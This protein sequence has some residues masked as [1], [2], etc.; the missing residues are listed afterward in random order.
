M[1]YSA[2]LELPLFLFSLWLAFV[3]LCEGGFSKAARSGAPN[4]VM[5]RFEIGRHYR[6]SH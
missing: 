6:L 4:F 2:V 5:K 1:Y 3:L